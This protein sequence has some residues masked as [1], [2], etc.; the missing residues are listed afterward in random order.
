MKPITITIL[1]NG[2]G[3]NQGLPYNAFLINENL[4]V[5]A[6]PDVWSYAIPS[7]PMGSSFR[8][9]QPRSLPILPTPFGVRRWSRSWS[10]HL[11][12]C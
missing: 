9:K 3:L 12:L 1:G 10:E 11:R 7:K 5:E 6:P 8:I 4:L 2:G